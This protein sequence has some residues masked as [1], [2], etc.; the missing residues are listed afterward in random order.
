MTSASA[1]ASPAG[2][3]P[4]SPPRRAH[5]ICLLLFL[6]QPAGVHAADRPYLTLSS[7][8][9]E[10]DDD[11]VGSLQTVV[12]ADRLVRSQAVSAEY[13]FDPL[14]SVQLEF[15][16]QRASGQ[17][18]LQAELEYKQLF[19]HI[20]R[21]GWAWGLSVS[22]GAD[23]GPGQAWHGGSWGAVLPLSLQLGEA[24]ATA[25][26]N[27]GL[28][29]ERL[30]RRQA[31]A[32]VGIEGLVARRTLLFAEASGLGQERL[33]HAGL[34][35]WIRRDRLALDVSVTRRRADGEWVRGW[36]LGLAWYDL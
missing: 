7:A 11:Q 24:V 4:T 15:T 29:R 10:E 18:R 20:A 30:E 6:A 1:A 16:R 17:T 26:L 9:A 33:L 22:L 27:L 2:P 5:V 12:R 32:A 34:R 36:L 19:N 13:A 35:Y 25:H 8:A 28:V 23:R 3:R 31:L 14:R 21:D